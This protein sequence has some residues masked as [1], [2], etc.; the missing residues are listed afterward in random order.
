ME[1]LI[2]DA[3]GE[4]LH[5]G[6]RVKFFYVAPKR[7]GLYEGYL[8]AWNSE[9]LEGTIESLDYDVTEYGISKIVC[10]HQRELCK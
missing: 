4:C 8:R 10:V 2:F 7:R 9:T 5:I 1:Q 6:D 3:F